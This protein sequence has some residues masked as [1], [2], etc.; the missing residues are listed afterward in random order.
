MFRGSPLCCVWRRSNRNSKL[1][2]KRFQPQSPNDKN[3]SEGREW[4]VRSVVV[5]FRFFGAPWFSVQTCFQ[6]F[7]GLWTEE[8][9]NQPRRIQPPHSRPL[10]QLP[11]QEVGGFLSTPESEERGSQSTHDQRYLHWQSGKRRPPCLAGSDRRIRSKCVSDRLSSRALVVMVWSLVWSMGTF[12]GCWPCRFVLVGALGQPK[13]K[14]W[15]VSIG[16]NARFKIE[17]RVPKH[18]FSKHSVAFIALIL[19]VLDSVLGCVLRTRVP[20][21]HS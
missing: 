4:G 13:L 11:A 19:I 16:E 6:G 8:L 18:A 7:G 15:P 3:S 5:D 20:K 21:I 2:R 14:E 12:M 9:E 1:V 10:K 17:T